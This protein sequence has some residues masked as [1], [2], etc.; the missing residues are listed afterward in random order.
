[1]SWNSTILGIQS[2]GLP[3]ERHADRVIAG[4]MRVLAERRA[5]VWDAIQLAIVESS[6]G[7]PKAQAKMEAR[8]R[9]AGA[10]YTS[11]HPGKR[12]KYTLLIYDF[13]GWD[14]GRD[15]EIGIGDA[16]PLKPWIACFASTV[17]SKGGGR[18]RKDFKSKA[19]LFVTHHAVSRMAQRLGV[20]TVADVLHAVKVIWTAAIDFI[21]EKKG[22]MEWLDAPPQGWRVKLGHSNDIVVL[23][24]HA[25]RKA[26]VAATVM[27]CERREGAA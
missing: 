8:I 26:L 9:A 15:A 17:I 10:A 23:K 25:K 21:T 4:M 27:D 6:D 3:P 14:A 2:I 19:V 18:D 12:G 13:C 5:H 20:R 16:I 1:M 24:R 22:N 7:N 11:L